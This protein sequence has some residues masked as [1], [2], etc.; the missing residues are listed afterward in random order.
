MIGSEPPV[1]PDTPS[2]D[3]ISFNDILSGANNLK[4]FY[5]A[6]KRL[7]NTVT[8][9]GIK[10]TLS[11]FTYLMAQ[12]I[13]HMKSSDKSNVVII[14]GIKNPSNS[15]LGDSID[16]QQLA[17]DKYYAAAYAVLNHMKN[18]TQAPN[19]VSTENTLKH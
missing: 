15:T 10:F 5:D 18:T 8:A 2:S 7:P 14:K 9:G 13:Y 3:S 6:N 4:K 11:E 1:T 12:A 17:M 16:N 19:F